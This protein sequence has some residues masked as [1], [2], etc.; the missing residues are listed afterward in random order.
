MQIMQLAA[1]TRHA[2]GFLHVATGINRVIS[3]KCIRLQYAAKMG[4]VQLRMLALAIQRIGDPSGWCC[5]RAG[6][7]IITHM[8]AVHPAPNRSWLTLQAIR[9]VLQV[10]TATDV[11]FIRSGLVPERNSGSS[12][13]SKLRQNNVLHQSAFPPS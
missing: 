6:A 1:R 7:S 13:P 4:E 2:S 9:V 10:V 11:Q 5:G 8:V 3:R 12:L